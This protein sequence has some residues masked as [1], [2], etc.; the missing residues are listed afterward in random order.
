MF[1]EFV[2]KRQDDPN[3]KPRDIW[4]KKTIIMYSRE[5]MPCL[6]KELETG[7]LST[8]KKPK[9][10][11]LYTQKFGMYWWLVRMIPDFHTIYLQWHTVMNA[12]IHKAAMDYNFETSFR[13]K[14]ELTDVELTMFWQHIESLE[15]GTDN[16]K[17]HYLT[18]L[19]VWVTSAR[20]GSFTV[21]YG[22]EKGTK[23]SSTGKLRDTDETLRWKD[24]QFFRHEGAVGFKITFRFMKNHRDPH[25]N[26]V[27]NATRVFTIFPVKSNR[28][29]LDLAMIMTSWAFSRGVFKCET[30]EELYNGSDFWIPLNNSKQDLPVFLKVDNAGMV[31]AGAAMHERSLNPKLQDICQRIGLYARNTLYSLRRTA[32]IETRRSAGTEQAQELA[33]HKM[34]GVAVYSYDHLILEDFDISN[35]RNNKGTIDRAG[36]RQMFSQAVIKRYSPDTGATDEAPANDTD[37]TLSTPETMQKALTRESSLRAQ[38]DPTFVESDDALRAAF[39]AGKE[40]LLGLD[41]EITEYDVRNSRQIRDQ[42]SLHADKATVKT[43]LANCEA[44]D[45]ERHNVLRRARLSAMKAIKLERLAEAQ[46]N[47]KVI[48]HSSKGVTGGPGS[49]PQAQKEM[50]GNWADVPSLTDSARQQIQAIEGLDDSET[51]ADAI[52][53]EDDD[54]SEVQRQEEEQDHGRHAPSN[55]VQPE[56]VD[57]DEV[58]IQP[59]NEEEE[60]ETPTQIG[61]INFHKEFMGLL[62]TQKSA[63]YCIQCKLDGTVTYRKKGE[64]YSSSE[65]TKHLKSG[66]HS[67]RQQV[68]RIFNI[69]KNDKDRC[70]CY[71]CPDAEDGSKKKMYVLKDFLSHMDSEHEVMMNL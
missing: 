71:C 48:S 49:I 4:S 46:A 8:N 10:G 45:A 27:I 11:A 36:I 35:A 23:I 20:P 42:L 3:M 68:T 66:F 32:I 28:Y 53:D 18:W 65:L 64:T 2:K 44:A 38:R 51:A 59:V 7:M 19:L 5:F 29:H 67:R 39:A 15:T 24:V 25:R 60:G 62:D 6:A 31:I 41:E 55:W 47:A 16:W 54:I 21:C 13:E 52:A 57:H 33:A 63:L 12:V 1:E 30:I 14:N 40:I 37:L 17:Q 50:M 56:D 61:R 22:Y 26:K 34:Q 58:A 70:E 9:A 69:D 43:A